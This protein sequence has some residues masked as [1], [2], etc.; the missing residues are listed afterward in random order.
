MSRWKAS[1]I[2]LL[3]S[4][5][6]VGS[7]LVFMAAVWYRWPLFEVAGGG[8][9][10]LILAGVDVTLGP[11]I[12]LV[13]FKSGKKGLKFDLSVIA[14]LQVAA[15]AYGIHVVSLARPVY[16][17][18]AFDRF[19]LVTAKDLDPQDLAK[20]TR[21]EF[22]RLPLGRPGYIAAELPRDPK[23]QLNI[24]M[25]AL[26]GKDLQ[27]YP[28]YYVPYEQQAQNVLRHAKPVSILLKRDPEAVRRYLISAG[29]SPESVKF[30]P[31]TARRDAA[32]LLDAVSGM[33]LEIVLADPW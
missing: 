1:G 29:R 19:N 24:I 31:L 3:L 28:Q 25:T 17:V 22:K 32:V 18:F 23:L 6:V 20:V 5:T 7:V 15:L 26:G 33:P 30:L 9:L 16:V 2:H 21:E 12:T 13:I 11:L 4:G 14:L 10:A 27:L 8:G